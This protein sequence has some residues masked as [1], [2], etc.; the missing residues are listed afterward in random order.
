MKPKSRGELAFLYGFDCTKTFTNRLKVKAIT[1]T[2][3]VLI[4]FEEQLPIYAHLG[5]PH[6]MDKEERESIVPFLEEY[7]EKNDL[8][9]PINLKITNMSI[10]FQ[11]LPT[12]AN[13]G[14]CAL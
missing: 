9:P 5:I 14:Y 3:R 6:L 10:F 12:I 8:P 4:S 2:K 11:R 13:F 1:I 7:C